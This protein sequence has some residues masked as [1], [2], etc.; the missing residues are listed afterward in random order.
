MEQKKLVD[1]LEPEDFVEQHTTL[2]SF[3]ERGTW[4]THSAQYRGNWSPYIARNLIFK[5]SKPGQGVLDN[6]CG[7]GTTAIETRLLG[8]HCLALDINQHAVELTKQSL[9]FDVPFELDYKPKVVQGDARDLAMIPDRKIELVCSHPPYGNAIRY[10]KDTP[11][12]LSLLEVVDF[13]QQMLPVAKES[14]RVTKPGGHCALLIGDLR[15][16]KKVVPLGF[17][18]LKVYNA[19]GWQ[20]QEIIVKEQHNC[21][22]TDSWIRKAKQYNFLLLAH[23]YLFVFQK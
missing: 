4:A 22:M 21:L 5:Y 2:W 18:L 9:N 15:K 11:G 10:S 3:P 8:R 12:D 19:V 16:H 14:Y 1:N 20:L 23:E 7:G 17:Q 13:L 6:F